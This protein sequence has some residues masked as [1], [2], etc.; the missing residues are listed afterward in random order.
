MAASH[1]KDSEGLLE[2]L[3]RAGSI[4]WYWPDTSRPETWRAGTA[5]EALG[6]EADHLPLTFDAFQTLVHPAD[7][8]RAFAGLPDLTKHVSTGDFEVEYRVLRADRTYEWVRAQTSFKQGGGRISAISFARRIDDLAFRD[9]TAVRSSEDVLSTVLEEIGH[10]VVLMTPDG[11]I[12]HANE[13]A[14]GVIGRPGRSLAGTRFCPFLH[15]EDGESV[16][17]GFLGEV[18]DSGQR[19][20]REIQRFDRWWRIYLVPLRAADRRVEKVLLLAQDTTS[21][22][23]LQAARL[24]HEQALT[25]T[26]VREVHHRIKNHLQGLVGL[27]RRY[28]DSGRT[29]DA[30]IDGAVAH[31]LSIAAVYGLFSRTGAASVELADLITQIISAMRGGSPIPLEFDFEATDWRPT[32]LS[33]DEAVPL[34]IAVGELLTN[35]MK[36]TTPGGD[37]RISGGLRCT[38]AGIELM[39]R[40]SPATLPADFDLTADREHY[41]GLDLVRALLPRDRSQLVILQEGGT[42]VARLFL[43]S[44]DPPSSPTPQH[45]GR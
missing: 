5:L 22:K 21:I 29:G 42:V 2:C 16:L 11:H 20:D 13:A 4:A 14:G 12:M 31:L 36:H 41:M 34:A 7:C 3:H 35:A 44:G 17:P 6:Y 8:A 32:V 39:I 1:A 38:S 23:N 18:V 15:E 43:R 27:M 45:K 9:W 37:A 25:E 19:Q 33:P 24:A 26:L 28:S 30:V 10:P 40:N